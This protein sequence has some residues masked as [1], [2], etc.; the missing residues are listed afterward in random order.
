MKPSSGIH[1][2]SLIS[3]V[4]RPLLHAIDSLA[5]LAERRHQHWRL[6][7]VNVSNNAPPRLISYSKMYTQ[8]SLDGELSI[9]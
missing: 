7:K 8:K 3:R 2:M 5:K 9:N 6:C 4:Q 1:A